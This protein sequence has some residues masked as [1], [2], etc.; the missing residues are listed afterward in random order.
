MGVRC[1][2]KGNPDLARFSGARIIDRD[3]CGCQPSTSVEWGRSAK[4]M[5]N[6]GAQDQSWG[7]GRS[8]GKVVESRVGLMQS[9]DHADGALVA[10]TVAGD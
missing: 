7:E 1:E 5:E 9:S 2:A 8:D 3:T 4:Q 6:S 10:L